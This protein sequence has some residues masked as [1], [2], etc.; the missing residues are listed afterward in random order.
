MATGICVIH[1]VVAAIAILVQAVGGGGVEV[2]GI[3]GG[4]EAAPLGRVV[5][6]VAVVQAGIFVVVIATVADGVGFCYGSVAGNGAIAP[7][8]Y[9]TMICAHSQEKAT[10]IIVIWVAVLFI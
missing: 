2:G 9:S 3:I 5:P 8:L 4:D 1:R 10:Q 7:H 6:G